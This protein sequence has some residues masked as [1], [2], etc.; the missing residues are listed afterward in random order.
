VSTDLITLSDAKKNKVQGNIILIG[1]TDIVDQLDP[2]IQIANTQEEGGLLEEFNSPY[3]KTALLLVISGKTQE[4]V[5]KAGRAFSNNSLYSRLSGAKAVIKSNASMSNIVR[6]NQL[7]TTL[8]EL[9]YSNGTASGTREQKLS[10]TIPLTSLWQ[11]KA[12]AILDLHFFHS[13]LTSEDNSTL[14]ISVNGLSVGSTKLSQEN[15]N[16]GQETFQIPLDFFH[17]GNNDLSIQ[18]NIQVFNNREDV[19]LYCAD[20]NIVEAWLT[21]DKDSQLKFPTLPDSST[22]DISN[23][24]YAFMGKSDLSQLAFVI[25]KA[26]SFSDLKALSIVALSLGRSAVGEPI[27][28][29]VISDDQASKNWQ[30]YPYRILIGLPLKNSAISLVNDRLPLSFDLSTGVANS[31]PVLDTI[32]SG[33]ISTGYIE[34]FLSSDKVPNLIISGNNEDGLLLAAD[35][36][37]LNTNIA[38]L[39]G[40]VAITTGRDREI[41]FWG[42]TLPTTTNENTAAAQ[43]EIS[44]KVMW[45]Q[46]NATLYTAVGFL[47]LAVLIIVIRIV[48]VLHTKEKDEEGHE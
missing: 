44:L 46:K 29:H 1:T 11:S 22:V 24:P 31:L 10:Y 48:M 39:G 34:A 47:I 19:E 8:E 21:I 32:D 12:D 33:K 40:D 41:S 36:M 28:L 42:T 45:F 27:M 7:S 5:E 4:D 18:A 38:K 15:A 37:G 35:Q 9:G 14:T 43:N 6:D 20:D 2:S 13:A 3:D 17:V 26:A 25:P 30:D 16:G 23:F